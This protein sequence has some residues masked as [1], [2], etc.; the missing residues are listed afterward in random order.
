MKIGVFLIPSATPEVCTNL[1]T[2][3]TRRDVLLGLLFP[4]DGI[5]F[6]ILR[7]YLHSSVY[8]SSLER[9]TFKMC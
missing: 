9:V 7:I 8:M 3:A 6:M 4:S 5:V 2:C 1:P